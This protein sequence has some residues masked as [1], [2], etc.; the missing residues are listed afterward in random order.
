MPEDIDF[1]DFPHLSVTYVHPNA[2]LLNS[3]MYPTLIE[4]YM[5]NL[6]FIT[7][8]TNPL[9]KRYGACRMAHSPTITHKHRGQ[10]K[11]ELI[12]WALARPE[13]VTEVL[14]RRR[15]PRLTYR[16]LCGRPG[17]MHPLHLLCDQDPR[18]VGLIQPRPRTA[19][20]RHNDWLTLPEMRWLWSR[21]TTSFNHDLADVI[22]EVSEA[23]GVHYSTLVDVWNTLVEIDRKDFYKTFVVQGEQT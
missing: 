7:D 11:S 8:S 3:L 9:P 20:N 14:A 22:T 4:R 15:L 17:C 23:I 21:M 19:R 1:I 18:N 16:T 6:E 13:A 10:V 5:S 12:T 2:H